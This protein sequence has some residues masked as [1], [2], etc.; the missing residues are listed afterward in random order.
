MVLD[1]TLVWHQDKVVV[2]FLLQYKN[3][4]TNMDY[5]MVKQRKDFDNMQVLVVFVY[6]Q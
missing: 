4:D 3:F 1:M 6:A 5:Q 2:V